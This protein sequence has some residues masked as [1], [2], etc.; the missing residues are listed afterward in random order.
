M[1]GF[2]FLDSQ[3]QVITIYLCVF[4]KLP[5]DDTS[6]RPY[7]FTLITCIVCFIISPLNSYLYIHWILYLLLL[8]TAKLYFSIE[9]ITLLPIMICI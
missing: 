4:L 5:L 7:V 1:A 9:S 6:G 3:Q 2:L 8:S